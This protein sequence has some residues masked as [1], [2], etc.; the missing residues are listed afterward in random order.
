MDCKY[1]TRQKT[2]WQRDKPPK[3][4]SRFLRFEDSR[5][6]DVLDKA[7]RHNRGVWIAL[8]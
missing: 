2:C 7:M 6:F 8:G 5:K 3:D 1:C 4:C